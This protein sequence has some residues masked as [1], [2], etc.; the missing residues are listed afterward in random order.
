MARKA[1]GIGGHFAN[2]EATK[3]VSKRIVFE[4]C[5][6]TTETIETTMN[7]CDQSVNHLENTLLGVIERKSDGMQ[8]R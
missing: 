7:K 3:R 1:E 5:S 4:C 8:L 2:V 6:K